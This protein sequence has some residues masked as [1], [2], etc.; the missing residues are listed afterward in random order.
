MFLDPILSVRLTNLGMS[1][2]NVGLAF[3]VIG[4][5][6]GFGSPI[7]GWLCSKI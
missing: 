4:F 3:G 6:F 5:S 7:A 1:A 2:D